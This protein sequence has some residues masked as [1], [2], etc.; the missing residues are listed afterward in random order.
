MYFEQSNEVTK[1]KITW[2]IELEENIIARRI[3]VYDNNH[4]Q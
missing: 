3:N 4:K 2:R 1:P